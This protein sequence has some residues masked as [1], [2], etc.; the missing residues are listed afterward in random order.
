VATAALTV[1]R[2]R[3]ELAA[4]RDLLAEPVAVVMTMGALHGGHVALVHEARRR[5]A[6][7]VVTIFV[8]P[9]QFAPG[10][11]FERYPRTLSADLEL[12]AGLGVD[13]VFA[14]DPGDVYP[15]QPTVRV[16]AGPLGDRLEG[17]HRPG[18][19]DGVLTVVAKLLNLVRP[20]VALFGEKD[21]QQLTLIRQM[22]A[23][24]DLPVQVASIGVVREPD[25]LA[26]SSRNRYLDASDRAAAS[27]LSAALRAATTAAPDGLAAATA[28]ARQV[29]AA[30]PRLQV[31]YLEAVDADT[32]D[33]PSPGRPVRLLVAARVGRTRLIDNT[34]FVP[35]PD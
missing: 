12:C 21:A 16:H 22:V 9:L 20:A 30:E 4:A 33:P 17:A 3:A 11:D 7:V 23:D 8:N 1:V 14:P 34:T 28:A 27:A 6:S 35:R 5:G 10:E 29:L 25:G 15:H 24:L 18:H 19:F 2:T 32:F 13:L 26:L 31:D